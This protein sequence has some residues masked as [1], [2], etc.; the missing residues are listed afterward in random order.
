MSYNLMSANVSVDDKATPD[1]SL[2]D[3]PDNEIEIN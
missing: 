3:L 2:I 1:S